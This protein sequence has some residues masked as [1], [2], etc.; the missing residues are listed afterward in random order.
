MS[1]AI[2]AIYYYKYYGKSADYIIEESRISGRLYD[3][4][5]KRFAA[6]KLLRGYR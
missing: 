5:W 2:K 1:E 3:M 6:A 4:G